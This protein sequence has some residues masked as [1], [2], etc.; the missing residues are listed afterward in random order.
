MYNK[1]FKECNCDIIIIQNQECI[2]FDDIILY[3]V[4]NLTENNYF[5]FSYYSTNNEIIN[6]ELINS[7]K[8][9]LKFIMK[10]LIKII[11]HE[12]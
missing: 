4:N 12:L 7:K 2:H 10:N 8:N 3:L 9:L 11:F 5:L 6:K 1:S